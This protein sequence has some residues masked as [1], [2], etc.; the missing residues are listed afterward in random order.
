[1]HK[2]GDP[3]L[4][5]IVVTKSLNQS[6]GMYRVIQDAKRF[7]GNLSSV[8]VVQGQEVPGSKVDFSGL[9]ARLASESTLNTHLG[10]G[11]AIPVRV[12]QDWLATSPLLC[13]TI[14]DYPS[15]PTPPSA[16][17]AAAAV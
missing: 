9:V 7:D 13:E 15:W 10:Q 12:L 3:E 14:G 17:S 11:Q 6:P 16:I 1:M 2:A 8:M 5:A 4:S